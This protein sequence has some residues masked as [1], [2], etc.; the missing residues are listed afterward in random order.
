MATRG[1]SGSEPAKPKRRPAT[2]PEALENRMIAKAYA[3]VEKKMD[4]GEASSMEIVHFLKL[5]SS[6]EKLEQMRI[7]EDIE[8]QKAKREVMASAQ[9]I[10]AMYAE[11][12]DAMRSYSGQG[13]KPLEL[14]IDYED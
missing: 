11:A 4:R 9:R 10:E 2:T 14:E 6:R 13:Q 3:T 5:G 8:L 12:L 1:T 7:A